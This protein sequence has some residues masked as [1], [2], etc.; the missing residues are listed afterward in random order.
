MLYLFIFLK[1]LYICNIY[2][3]MITTIKLNNISPYIVT[4]YVCDEST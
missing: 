4:F 3:E 2:S 1:K